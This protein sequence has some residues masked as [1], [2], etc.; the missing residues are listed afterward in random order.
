MKLLLAFLFKA[1]GQALPQPSSHTS[2]PSQEACSPEAA[3]NPYRYSS[4][5]FPLPWLA[6]QTPTAT[7]PIAFGDSSIVGSS[8]QA[9]FFYPDAAQQISTCASAPTWICSC[10]TEHCQAKPSERAESANKHWQAKPSE[11][12]KSDPDQG[13]DRDQAKRAKPTK[14]AE[15]DQDQGRDRGQAKR[16]NRA[17]PANKHW[18]AK[19]SK[20]AK[21]DQDSGRDQDQAKRAKPTKRAQSEQDQDRDR[22]SAACTTRIRDIF[23]WTSILPCILRFPNLR[24]QALWSQPRPHPNETRS[25]VAPHVPRLPS[26]RLRNAEGEGDTASSAVSGN[27]QEPSRS[28]GS[29]GNAPC[30]HSVPR[31]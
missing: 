29:L 10:S 21:S 16:T 27:Q 17:E 20:R 3:A 2:P 14:R 18:Q 19:P 11:R 7:E 24:T 15:S 13:R 4:S 6:Q 12:A 25:V 9:C 26:C 23:S 31:H 30:S 28:P 5:S 1:H 8:T 22:G